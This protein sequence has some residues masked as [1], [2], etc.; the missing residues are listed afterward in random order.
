MNNRIIKK[1]VC[2]TAWLVTTIPS[3]HI[4]NIASG[5]G[6]W[7]CKL[8][9]LYQ[10]GPKPAL[11]PVLFYI[12]IFTVGAQSASFPLFKL[13]IWIMWWRCVGWLDYAGVVCNTKLD[14]WKAGNY[15]YD[16][17]HAILTP[18]R[19]SLIWPANII[20]YHPQSLS[21]SSIIY[22]PQTRKG[23]GF[24]FTSSPHLTSAHLTL[25]QL[26]RETCRPV[27]QLDKTVRAELDP[28]KV[29]R[30]WEILN[31]YQD[32]GGQGASNNSAEWRDLGWDTTQVN[33]Q[34]NNFKLFW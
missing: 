9:T 18:P 21:L 3:V 28:T 5:R 15:P 11:L 23:K 34:A 26:R 25:A 29:D 27:G 16:K 19:Q 22:I 13:S 10:A 24:R 32:N 14:L 4:K 17:S 12:S 30:R 6:W 1:P 20:Y 31:I 33:Q 7:P 8:S 2:L